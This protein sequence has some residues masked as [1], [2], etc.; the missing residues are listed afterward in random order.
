MK[1]RE[2]SPGALALLAAFGLVAAACGGAQKAE[3]PP[4]FYSS[5]EYEDNT[6]PP[7]DPCMA[8]RGE[9]RDCTSNEDCCEG[10]TCS[11]DPERSHIRRYCIE[12]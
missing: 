6:P 4:A 10:F 3:E 2:R 5:K 1:T 7:P 11:L 9:P 8:E 12:G